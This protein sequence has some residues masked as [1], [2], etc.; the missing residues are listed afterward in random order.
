M[1]VVSL[2]SEGFLP[3]L[4]GWKSRRAATFPL[5]GRG[6]NPDFAIRPSSNWH[7][8]RL[9]EARKA[10]FHSNSRTDG[11]TMTYLKAVA[12]ALAIMMASGMIADYD[13][14]VRDDRIDVRVWAPDDQSD[15]RLR[16]QVAAVLGRHVD[17]THVIVMYGDA[18]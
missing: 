4:N 12:G 5:V 16:K 2:Q 6:R 1:I 17:E 14:S 3:L 10:M 9:G 7:Q 11:A 15:I 18:A 13:V 8:R